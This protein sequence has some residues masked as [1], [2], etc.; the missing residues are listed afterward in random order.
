MPMRT[1]T[2]R[3]DIRAYK[4]LWGVIRVI[5]VIFTAAVVVLF[6]FGGDAFAENGVSYVL[7]ACAIFM[8]WAAFRFGKPKQFRKYEI[9]TDGEGLW[10][11]SLGKEVG[12]VRWDSVDEVREVPTTQCLGRPAC[13]TRR[14]GQS[15]AQRGPPWRGDVSVM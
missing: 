7:A 11:T 4:I 12:L 9:S 3:M 5:A 6:I 1:E 10:K 13:Q 2:F 8:L 15:R 14:P